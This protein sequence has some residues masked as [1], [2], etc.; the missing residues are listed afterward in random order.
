MHCKPTIPNSSPWPNP[1]VSYKSHVGHVQQNAIAPKPASQLQGMQKLCAAQ[2]PTSSL[3]CSASE[4]GASTGT[5]APEPSPTDVALGLGE[6]VR[7]GPLPATMLDRTCGQDQRPAGLDDMTTTDQMHCRCMHCAQA[8]AQSYSSVMLCKVHNI[9][10]SGGSRSQ[11]QHIIMACPHQTCTCPCTHHKALS[12]H[13]QPAPK[14]PYLLRCCFHGFHKCPPC[15]RPHG[16][17]G[18]C[19]I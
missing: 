14:Q 12:S 2:T 9:T 8:Q 18:R 16:Q 5:A 11:R 13:P 15:G 7:A 17:L 4:P 19:Q 3:S 10:L 1:S 6:E